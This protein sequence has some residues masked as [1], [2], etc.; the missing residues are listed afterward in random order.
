MIRK[1]SYIRVITQI[2]N[3]CGQVVV[4]VLTYWT[5]VALGGELTL[6]SVFVGITLILHLQALV[7]AGL[8]LAI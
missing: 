5:Y 1:A 7:S 6:D 4:I 3:V 8:P 2:M